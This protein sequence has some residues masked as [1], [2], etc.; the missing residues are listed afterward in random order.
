MPRNDGL[1][2]TG[3]SSN[4]QRLADK[5]QE[6]IKEKQADREQLLPVADLILAEIEKMKQKNRERLVQLI[7]PETPDKAA[8]AIVLG[9]KFN[10]QD[11]AG[12]EAK[13]KIILRPPKSTQRAV[14]N[15]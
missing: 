13:L 10:D 12:L 2:Y 4:S 7:G 15:E 6:R 5:R 9:V 3:A 11:I 14:S 1:L 8:K